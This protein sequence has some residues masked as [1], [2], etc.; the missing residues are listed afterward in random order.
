MKKIFAHILIFV[1]I[2]CC[3]T[4]CASE[5]KQEPEK[6]TSAVPST[7]TQQPPNEPNEETVALDEAFKSAVQGNLTLAEIRGTYH[8]IGENIYMNKHNYDMGTYNYDDDGTGR[9]HCF[10][11]QCS[12]DIFADYNQET[13]SAVFEASMNMTV[14]FAKAQ[15]GNIYC[16]MSVTLSGNPYGEFN[17]VRSID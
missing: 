15:D 1:L 4:G 17:A 14:T 16:H 11:P 3:F 2:L 13:S 8:F 12:D 7:V 5:E 10:D 9:L 6:E